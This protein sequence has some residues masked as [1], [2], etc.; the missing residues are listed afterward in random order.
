MGFSLRKQCGWSDVAQIFACMA[1]ALQDEWGIT[2]PLACSPPDAAT[3]AAVDVWCRQ[4]A[5]DLEKTI[6]PPA[7]MKPWILARV[8]VLVY[9]A[10]AHVAD[11][12]QDCPGLSP[13]A[14]RFYL[15]D[16]WYGCLRAWWPM[17]MIELG[18]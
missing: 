7:D 18:S 3:D 14:V 2:P 1:V 12:G 6:D 11:P 16:L 8:I 13:A 15:I 17:P 9:A 10:R 5:L 4:L